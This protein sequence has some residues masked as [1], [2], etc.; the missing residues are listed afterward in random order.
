MIDNRAEIYQLLHSITEE[1]SYRYPEDLLD[2]KYPKVCYYVSNHTDKD[3]QDNKASSVLIEYTI[4]IYEKNVNGELIEIHSE[5][6]DAIKG[7]GYMRIYFDNYFDTEDKV[8][9]YTLKYA[10]KLSY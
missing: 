5:I 9:I 1:V 2:N 4:Q 10:K 8:N 6:D 7:A 3:Y